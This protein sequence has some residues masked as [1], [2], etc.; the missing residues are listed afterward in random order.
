[1]E[2]NI[3]NRLAGL[4]IHIPY[5]K[6]KCH[7]C[8]FHFSVSLRTKD[9]LLQALNNELI[10]RK[11]E[12]QEP[13]DTIYLGGGTP[14]ILTIKEL[15]NLFYTIEKNYSIN[16]NP[17]ITLEA[18]PDDLTKAYIKSLKNTPV[19]RLS[20]GVQSFFDDDLQFMNRAHSAIEA[21]NSIKYAQDNG[22]E[23]ISIDL[24]YGIPNLTIQKWEQN[25]KQFIALKIPH[26]SSYALTVE[27]KTALDYFIKSKQVKPLNDDLAVQ[28]F[29]HLLTALDREKYIHYELSNFA[30]KS[31]LSKHN[32]S[33][34]QGKSY[35]GIGPSA[36]SFYNNKRSWNIANNSRYSKSVL[37][38]VIPNEIEILS[39]T[40][41]YNEYIMT[42]LRTM[43]GISLDYLEYN[44]GKG[45]RLYFDDKIKP[46]LLNNNLQE[47]DGNTGKSIR[48][49]KDS[50][51]IIDG[52]IADLFWVD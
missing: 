21:L 36:H 22:F 13:I 37:S 38:D 31:F 4:Y 15:K 18:N 25:I 7:Y 39:T 49:H 8:D 48:V 12:I 43:W 19:N 51:F 32:T 11:K 35:L 24:I 27:P 33:Y 16:T 2:S 41:R 26:L 1:L 50:Y 44:I 46:Y 29:K 52:I 9:T 23:N 6:Q 47:V 45:Y 17:E 34:W 42:G 3:L 5:C 10:L 30:K 28:H 40:D 14:S 20:I